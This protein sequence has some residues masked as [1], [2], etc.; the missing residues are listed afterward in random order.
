MAYWAI[1]RIESGQAVC[2]KEDGSYITLNLADLPFSVKE[3]DVLS[4][5]DAGIE[6]D[7]AE[8]QRRKKQ[9]FKRFQ[10]LIQASHEEGEGSSSDLH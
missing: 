9:A 3:G 10:F 6:I 5:T 1:D 2:E 4:V 7:K 8:T